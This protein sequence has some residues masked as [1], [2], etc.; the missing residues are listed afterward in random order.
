VPV[1]FSRLA[2]TFPAQPNALY[3]ERDDR[4]ARGLPVV[5]LV[6]GNVTEQGI[7]FPPEL[8]DD[9][10]SAA[11]QRARPYRPN[12]LGQLPA[13]EAISEYYRGHGTEIPAQQ[14]VLTPGTSLAYWYV[15]SVFC[16]PCDEVLAPRPS[17]PLF[18]ELAGLARVQMTSYR[19]DETRDWAIDMDSL[20]G[21]ITQR[22]RAI[23]LI[24]PHNP[25]GAVA[26][27]E[28]IDAIAAVAAERRLPIV[29]D[30]V[31]GEF[32]FGL[33]G[34][35]RPAVTRAPLVVTLNG[36]SKLLALPGMKLG[37]MA[38]SGEAPE[39]ARALAAF[40]R[41]SDA[42]LPVNEIVQAAVPRL[43][44][45]GRAFAD[46]YRKEIATR[47]DDFLDILTRSA[48]VSVIAP[49]GGFYA[50]VRVNTAWD[51]ETLAMHILRSSDCLVHPGFFYDLDPTHLVL[52]VVS[53]PETGR[54]AL[55]RVVAAIDAAP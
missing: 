19:L 8:L 54:A 18:D 14:I 31:F 53:A 25:T 27:A 51:D 46:R 36:F 2:S 43:F 24:S 55:S 28:E 12:P 6:S 47:R 10:F 35:P 45:D 29:A 3:R 9:I 30:E 16:D 44:S 22:T 48:R 50:A 5:D 49:R 13:R 32:L 33:D 37:W 52:S 15:F 41:I 39:V 34:L 17:Y 40:E 38:L 20:V 21:A 23:I 26:S 7:V 4:L 42:L 11:T 1:R